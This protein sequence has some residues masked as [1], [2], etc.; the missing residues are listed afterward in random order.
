MTSVGEWVGV[1]LKRSHGLWCNQTSLRWESQHLPLVVSSTTDFSAK[2]KK[3]FEWQWLGETVALLACRL[4]VFD[5]DRVFRQMRSKPMLL[6]G[7]WFW[8]WSHWSEPTGCTGRSYGCLTQ[9]HMCQPN[10]KPR[11]QLFPPWLKVHSRFPL[12]KPRTPYTICP[13][14][15]HILFLLVSIEHHD[16]TSNASNLLTLFDEMRLLAVI[17]GKS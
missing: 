17:L 7:Q 14:Y 8:T 13:T 16:A 5:D 4:D 3:C 6:D 10:A 11:S 15:T 12:P 9:P 2:C 1:G